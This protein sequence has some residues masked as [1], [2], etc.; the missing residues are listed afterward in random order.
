MA[1]TGNPQRSNGE[2]SPRL[3]DAPGRR[4]KGKKRDRE[5]AITVAAPMDLAV[6]TASESEHVVAAMKRIG[7]TLA[8][9]WRLHMLLG[10]G[11]M[12]AVFGATHRNGNRVAIKML[13]PGLGHSRHLR[14][15][16]LREGYAANRVD[17][18]G[19]VRVLDDDE[20]ED[21]SAFLVME[22]L[23]GETLESRWQRAGSRL[24]LAEVLG[25]ADELLSVLSAAHAKG[26]HHRD[27]KPENVFLTKKGRLK[28]LDF[29]IAQM[30][31]GMP[32]SVTTTSTGIALGTPAFMPPEQALGRSREIDGRT[33][34]WALGATMFTLLTG[35]FVHVTESPAEMLVL[36]ATERAPGLRTVVPHVPESVAAIVDRALSFERDNRFPD[37]ETMRKAVRDARIALGYLEAETPEPV[38]VAVPSS[39]ASSTAPVAISSSVPAVAKRRL[40]PAWVAAM[41]AAAVAL[42]VVP[43]KPWRA[44]A[45]TPVDAYS[46]VA[47]LGE[48]VPADVEPEPE[49]VSPAPPVVPPPAASSAAPVVAAPVAAG[50]KRLPA[51]QPSRKP[52]AKRGPG[53]VGYR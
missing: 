40:R 35:R 7:T 13:H 44:P 53:W 41:A 37:A 4:R 36:A 8:G 21:G 26:I 9:K 39:L 31:D 23:S 5:A 18:E 22:L 15:R 46:S 19:V 52:V 25:V 27:I 14:E 33:D 17:H 16:F 50:P 12:A 3:K 43:I 32:G 48:A 2:K 6:E 28:V 51:R 49:I 11:G 30:L 34:L 20:L 45:Y 10:V 1:T 29:G 47:P 24:P 38:E 42:L